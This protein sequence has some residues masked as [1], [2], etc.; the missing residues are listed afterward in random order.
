MVSS[1]HDSGSILIAHTP[2]YRLPFWKRSLDLSLILLAFPV[3]VVWMT[4]IAIL[5][6]LVSPGRVFFI[7]ERIGVNGSRFRCFKFRSMHDDPANAATHRNH[8]AK[9]IDSGAPMKKL[10]L[11]GD[12]RLIRFG[13][14]LRATGLDELPQLFNVLKGEMSLVGPRPCMIYEY[15]RYSEDQHE[16]FSVLPGL[17]G[18]WQVS[19]KNKMSFDQMVDFDVRYAR[20]CSLSLDCLIV[21]RTFGT[22]C[23]QVVEFVVARFFRSSGD[24]G[25]GVRRKFVGNKSES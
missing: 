7:Q 25:G 10:D 9:L 24:G 2:T 21:V 18:L 5:I 4:A 11:E 3:I 17:T 19:G 1:P 15:E 8:L 13:G 6:K 16:R 20:R 23:R 14:F 12:R 22:L